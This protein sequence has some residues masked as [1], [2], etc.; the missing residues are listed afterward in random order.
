MEFYFINTNESNREGEPYKKWLNLG[1]AF[2]SGDRQRFGKKLGNPDPGDLVFMYVS[3]KGIKAVGMVLKKWDG[4]E[5]HEPLIPSP[6]DRNEFRLQINWFIVPQDRFVPRS[7]VKE[8]LGYDL[9]GTSARIN[10]D[11]AEKL[12]RYM[13][14]MLE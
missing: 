5:Y 1:Y 9:V 3:G 12:L 14:Q 6:P 11:M 13:L 4:I 7:K 2:T 8:I 10:H